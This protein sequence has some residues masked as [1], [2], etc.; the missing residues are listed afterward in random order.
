[1][2]LSTI[3]V[4]KP[5]KSDSI[6]GIFLI[7]V[8]LLIYHLNNYEPRHPDDLGYHGGCSLALRHP[9]VL[10]AKTAIVYSMSN[11]E[12]GLDIYVPAMRYKNLDTRHSIL[13]LGLG[14]C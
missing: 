8:H 6:F 10:A 13:G 7:F 9:W 14:L 4:T 2:Q 3:L 11:L 1:M 5:S 12:N